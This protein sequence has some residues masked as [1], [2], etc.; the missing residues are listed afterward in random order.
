MLRYAR[1]RFSDGLGGR[2]GLASG[3]VLALP[4]I[5]GAFDCVVS[6]R[7]LHH[8]GEGDDRRRALSELARISSRYLIVSLWTD[9]N[10]KAWRRK[11]LE[12]RRGPRAYQ[13]RFIVPRAVLEEEFQAVGLSAIGH[14]DLIPGYSQW[15]YYVLEKKSLLEKR[16]V[17]AGA[18]PSP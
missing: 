1:D 16:S 18:G 8:F 3:S 17:D 13:N 15:R 5:D 7:L 10:Y 2:F 12:N 11:R 4:F 14:H 9:G 6:M